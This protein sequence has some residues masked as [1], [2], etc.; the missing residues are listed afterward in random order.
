MTDHFDFDQTINREGSHSLKYD[1]R[2]LLF[3][4]ANVTPMWVADMDFAP[5]PAVT[6]ALIERAK[7]PILGYTLEPDSLFDA[8]IQWHKK[9]HG[10]FGI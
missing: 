8:L 7:H 2:K 9:R 4:D 5:P 3:G 1:L 10:W 6:G